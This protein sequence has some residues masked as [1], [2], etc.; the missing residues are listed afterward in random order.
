MSE[1]VSTNRRCPKCKSKSFNVT[2]T[3]EALMT[4]SIVNGQ[5]DRDEGFTEFGGFVD[6]LSAHCFKCDHR[7]VMRADQIDDIVEEPA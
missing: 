1:I 3:T 4:W 6:R 7:W 2:E 5:F